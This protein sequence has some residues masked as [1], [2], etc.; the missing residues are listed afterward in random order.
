MATYHTSVQ[1]KIA[2]GA[3]NAPSGTARRAIRFSHKLAGTVTVQGEPQPRNV[4]VYAPSG[5][6]LRRTKSASDG[7]WEVRFLQAARYFVVARDRRPEPEFEAVIADM[8]LP[9]PME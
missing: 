5:R 2:I 9:A 6:L 1:D 4:Y 3:F 8:I 7:T